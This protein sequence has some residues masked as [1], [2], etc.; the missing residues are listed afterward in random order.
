MQHLYGI[1]ILLLGCGA[2]VSIILW[3]EWICTKAELKIK[4]LKTM[5]E[6][7]IYTEA[8]LISFGNYVLSERRKKHIEE[9]HLIEVVGDWDIANW[10]AQE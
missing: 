4:N 9:Q 8:D 6:K 10:N 2:L 1:A 7:K 3:L 5:E